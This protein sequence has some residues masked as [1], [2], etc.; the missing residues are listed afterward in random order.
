MRELAGRVIDR[1]NREAGNEANKRA[2]QVAAEK[3][4]TVN[5]AAPRSRKRCCRGNERTL[6]HAQVIDEF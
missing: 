4:R 1:L 6:S 2:E 3:L 5:F